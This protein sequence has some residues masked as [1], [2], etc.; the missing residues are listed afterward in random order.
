MKSSFVHYIVEALKNI[1]DDQNPI[2]VC[3]KASGVVKDTPA[4]L[5]KI[6]QQNPQLLPCSRILEISYCSI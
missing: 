4:K 1:G 6:F 3:V 5:G 2:W